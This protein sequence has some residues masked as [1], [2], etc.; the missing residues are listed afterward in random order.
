[1]GCTVGRARASLKWVHNEMGG[2]SYQP[3][4]PLCKAHKTGRPAPMKRSHLLSLL[5]LSPSCVLFSFGRLLCFFSRRI[6]GFSFAPKAIKPLFDVVNPLCSGLF[7]T[8][9]S[10]H[11]LPGGGGPRRGGMM[12]PPLRTL[13][14]RGE[15]TPWCAS[16]PLHP[17]VVIIPYCTATP[18]HSGKVHLTG[19]AHHG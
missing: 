3:M 4:F 13:D 12:P 19:E 1:M 11:P 10:C 17:N 2:G 5:R 15:A 7:V 8:L 9:R 6:R 18:L 16:S 14:P